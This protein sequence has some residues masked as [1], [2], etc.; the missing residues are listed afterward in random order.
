MGNWH[1]TT[2]GCCLL[3]NGKWVQNRWPQ[4]TWCT[5]PAGSCCLHTSPLLSNLLLFW[6][7]NTGSCF[8][9]HFLIFVVV[10]LGADRFLQNNPHFSCKLGMVDYFHLSCGLQYC[11]SWRLPPAAAAF[12]QNV[13]KLF[14]TAFSQN[15]A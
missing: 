13:T 3:P 5:L 12:S 7:G 8:L 11:P 6:F 1:G 9:A 10:F 2:C 14:R 15:V 4:V